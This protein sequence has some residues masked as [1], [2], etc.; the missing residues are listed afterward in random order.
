MSPSEKLE[1]SF[2]SRVMMRRLGTL[3]VER[4]DRVQSAGEVPK[5]AAALA[6]G[7]SAVIFPEG[8][9]RRAAGLRGF[10]LGGFLAAARAGAPVF[11]A[12]LRGTRHVFRDDAPIFR[13][14]IVELEVLPPIWPDGD[15]WA[16]GL[17]LRDRVRAAMVERL[18]RHGEPDLAAAGGGD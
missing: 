10:R 9:F 16:A 4:F 18:E 12:A 8:T 5:A 3:L 7:E 17:L 15:D 1:D 13:R 11:P 2:L 6:G 14:G